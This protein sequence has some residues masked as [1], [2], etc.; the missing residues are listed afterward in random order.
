[1]TKALKTQRPSVPGVFCDRMSGLHRLVNWKYWISATGLQN[2]TINYD[3]FW[4]WMG[5]WNVNTYKP[6]CHFCWQIC[7]RF[8]YRS[9][10]SS[11]LVLLLLLF[12]PLLLMICHWCC[13]LLLSLFTFFSSYFPME[14]NSPIIH[15]QFTIHVY[16]WISWYSDQKNFIYIQ[17]I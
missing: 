4:K 14:P 13:L 2:L 17:H 16:R 6:K 9:N 5:F 12:L 15:L 7:A 11:Q 1:M 3:V 8:L 10:E